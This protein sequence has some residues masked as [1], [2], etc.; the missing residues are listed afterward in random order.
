VIAARDATLERVTTGHTVVI[1]GAGNEAR[2][3]DELFL[4]QL[5]ALDLEA[6]TGRQ[7]EVDEC[8][9]SALGA[10]DDDGASWRDAEEWDERT[11]EDLR[12]PTHPGREGADTSGVLRIPGA[13]RGRGE[14]VLSAPRE[15]RD[16]Q[17][18]L[19]DL[20]WIDDGRKA[21]T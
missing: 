15:T 5:G 3:R 19:D 21:W 10:P 17:L 13:G 6:V 11:L 12:R 2:E 1:V 14:D 4:A 20:V 9:R 18:V 8:P 7:A 16:S